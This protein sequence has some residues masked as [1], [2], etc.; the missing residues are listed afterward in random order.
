MAPQVES[1]GWSLS[2]IGSGVEVAVGQALP[3]AGMETA[4]Q[5]AGELVALVAGGSSPQPWARG[6]QNDF[7][8]N[9]GLDQGCRFISFAYP[10]MDGRTG[11][12][13]K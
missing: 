1:K 2:S 13:H 10:A 3:G 9:L 6:G 8:N 7:G 12:D 4:S 11:P 5:A